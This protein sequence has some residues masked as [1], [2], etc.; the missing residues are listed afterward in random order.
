MYS[1]YKLNWYHHGGGLVSKHS[2]REDAVVKC[3]EVNNNKEF[4]KRN[5][6]CIVLDGSDM[7]SLGNKHAI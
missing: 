7:I 6:Y 1:V 3:K 5:G 4:V 2:K